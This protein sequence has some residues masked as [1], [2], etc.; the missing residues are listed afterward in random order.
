MYRATV[1]FLIAAKLVEKSM[2]NEL[3]ALV[4]PLE[5]A[6][7]RWRPEVPSRDNEAKQ[8]ALALQEKT[9]IIYAGP[10]MY[11]AAYK[12]KIDAN[13]NAKNTAWCNAFP[14]LNHNEF[15]GWSSHPSAKPF[16]V[17]DLISGFE[18][19]RVLRRFEVTDTML[20]GMKPKA[21]RVEA[22]GGSALEHMVYLVLLGDLTTLYLALLNRVDPTPVELVEEF[23]K[24]LG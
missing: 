18:H 24:T 13:E 6:M 7:N 9:P 21:L 12:W 10:L 22:K 4:D 23:K 11:P 3:P 20:E 1:E 2:L 15:I 16:A 17:I 8:L 14:E 19:P 5:T